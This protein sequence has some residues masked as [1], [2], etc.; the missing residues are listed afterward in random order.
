MWAASPIR[1][2]SGFATFD[3]PTVSLRHSGLLQ[4]NAERYAS[5]SIVFEEKSGAAIV[6][7]LGPFWIVEW[8]A[9]GAIIAA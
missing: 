3:G 9:R 5:R 6:F 2:F 7:F 8:A 4:T 1:S